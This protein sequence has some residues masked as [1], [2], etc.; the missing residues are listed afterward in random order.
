MEAAMKKK[1]ASEP[2]PPPPVPQGKKGKQPPKQAVIP[3][4]PNVLAEEMQGEG[5]DE[6]ELV[7]GHKDDAVWNDKSQAQRDAEGPN[8]EDDP[9]SLLYGPDGKKLSNKERKKILKQREAAAR[10]AE[11]E[12][13]AVKNSKEGAQFACSQTAVNEKDPQWENSMDIGIPNFSIS[14]AGKIL[15][16]DASLTI[17]HGR[18]YGLVGANG[19]GKSTLLK[20]IASKDL[21]LPPRIDYLYVEQEVVADDTPAVEAVLKADQVRWDLLIEEKILMAKVDQGD[22]TE[23]TIERLGAVV[24]LLVNMGSDAMEAKARRI[25]YGLGFT[26]DMQTKPTKMFSGGWRMRISLARALF[27]EPTLLMLDEP[28]NHLVRTA[29]PYLYCLH[30]L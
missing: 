5:G 17:G 21:K 3:E 24:E 2:E 15:F 19:R 4:T 11:Y 8:D 13:V 22:E 14:A 28:T 27:V 25:L 7:Y 26:M 29:L 6:S 23:A 12:A 10:A 9:K 16:K 1:E 30:Y 18:R 20:M